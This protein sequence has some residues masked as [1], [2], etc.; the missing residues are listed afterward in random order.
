LLFARHGS[1][2]GVVGRFSTVGYDI[3]SVEDAKV[4]ITKFEEMQYDEVRYSR[5]CEEGFYNNR[6]HVH[7]IRFKKRKKEI[8]RI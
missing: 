2:Y 1:I 6:K 7:I 8:K 4:F 5:Y 3:I